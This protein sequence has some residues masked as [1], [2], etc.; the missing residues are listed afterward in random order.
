MITLPI[1]PSVNHLYGRNGHKTYITPIG[2]AWFEEA[3]WM[4]KTQWKKKMIIG[5]VALYIKLYFCGRYDWDNGNKAVSD[6]LTKMRVYKDDGQV[7][8]AQ[9]EKIRV[10]HRTDTKVTL[11]I[12]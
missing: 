5:E 4:I 9:I 1:P 2:Q 7:M 8:F 11:E 10:K 12:V 3:G 6:L